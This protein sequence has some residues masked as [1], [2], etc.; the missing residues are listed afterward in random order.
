LGVKL[1]TDVP[2]ALRHLLCVLAL[3]WTGLVNGQPFFFATDSTN[4]IRAADVAIYVASHHRF[5]TVWTDRYKG[6]LETKPASATARQAQTSA[7]QISRH[8]ANDL[9]QGVI[10]GG[11]SPYIG[12]LMYLGYVGGDFWPFVLFQ[13]V[14][15]YLLILLALRRFGITNPGTV[16]AIT[17]ALAATTSLP[18]Y[19]SFLLADAFASFGILAFLLLATPGQ[20][21]KMELAFLGAVLAISVSAHM[22]H[23]MMLIGMVGALALIARLRLVPK[24]PRRAWVAGVAGILVGLFS[25]QLTA[26]ATRLALGQRPQLMPLM[27]ARFIADGPGKRFIDSGCDQGRFQICHM[28]IGR[29]NSAVL[30]LFGTTPETGAYMLGDAQQRL[31]MGQQDTSFALAVLKYDPLGELWAMTRNTV[32]QFFWIDYDGLNQNCFADGPDCWA[33]LPPSIRA[34]LQSTPS[35]RGLWPQAAMNALLYVTVAASL[36]LFV[37]ALPVIARRNARE[38]ILLR[39]WLLLALVAMLVS[40]FFGGAVSD[41]QYR[42]QGRLIWLVP[43]FAA[44]AFCLWRRALATNPSERQRVLDPESAHSV[45]S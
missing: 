21:S 12:A 44:I 33:S 2:K 11:R 28:P 16:T 6:Q 30:I 25:V 35:G 9:R 22:T 36:L 18:T 17:L 39:E 27:T 1:R 43:F 24:P 32:R 41:P 26:E 19:N 38:W 29:P 14:I 20:L 23:I 37:I 13:A 15:A 34:K 42:Y 3:M 5:S 10:M 7:E 4:Y 45:V 40:S 31:R 8:S